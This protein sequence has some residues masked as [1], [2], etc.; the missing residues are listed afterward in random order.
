MKLQIRRAAIEDY[1]RLTEIAHAAKRHWGY[2]ER[3][4]AL[5]KETLTI[6]P[7]FISGSESYVA[8]VDDE[9]VG[10][11]SLIIRDDKTVLDHLWVMPERIG[12]GLGKEL[13]NHA[14]G[15][16]RRFGVKTIEIESDPY[17]EGFYKHMGARRVGEVRSEIEGQPRI[18][19]LLILELEKG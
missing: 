14:V 11:Y 8:V 13:F 2:P 12:T 5:W 7:E 6:T 18:L 10:F 9:V 4:I 3:W 19:P 1:E 15:T 17:A 16:A